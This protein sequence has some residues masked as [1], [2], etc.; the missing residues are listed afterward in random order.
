VDTFLIAN[1]PSQPMDHFYW[2]GAW[3]SD[4]QGGTLFSAPAA[5][6]DPQRIDVMVLGSD[7]HIWH[8][9]CSDC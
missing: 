8:T 3:F 2:R 1:I 9:W 4:T 7:G 5:L 6:A